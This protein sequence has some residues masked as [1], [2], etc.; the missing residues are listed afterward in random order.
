MRYHTTNHGPKRFIVQFIRNEH[1][2]IPL[3]TIKILMK[4]S[5]SLSYDKET[6]SAWLCIWYRKFAPSQPCKSLEIE[7][8]FSML[9]QT[10]IHKIRSWISKSAW[11]KAPCDFMDF[12]LSVENVRILKSKSV[13]GKLLSIQS[14]N[15]LQKRLK[16]LSWNRWGPFCNR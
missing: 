3:V 7:K 6:F 16:V 12:L 13:L 11:N 15:I 4:V 14:T 1:R 5:M 9:Q 10:L 2:F 8:F